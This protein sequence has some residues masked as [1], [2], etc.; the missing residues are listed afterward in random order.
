MDNILIFNDGSRSDIQ[1]L[2]ISLDLF[3]KATGMCINAKKSS[4]LHEGLSGNEVNRIISVLLF[5]EKPMKDNF[6]YLGFHL[7]LDTYRKH[8]WHWLLAK[9]E[10]RIKHWSYKW[11][12][13]AGRLVLI[14]SVL[15]AI[16]VYWIA[17]H[18]GPKRHPYSD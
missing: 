15:L 4:I 13:R 16:P 9:S 7:K 3:F 5:E 12:S 1:H 18:M 2:K 8:D 6:K 17:L 10:N 11:L 14:K